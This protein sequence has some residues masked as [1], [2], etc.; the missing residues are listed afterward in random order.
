MPTEAITAPKN[1]LLG[2]GHL[3]LLGYTGQDIP[4]EATICV[5]E[6]RL[7]F[8][9]GGATL[10]YKPTSYTANDD[11]GYV[12]KSILQKED[13]IFK[14]GILTFNGETVKKLADTARVIEGQDGSRTTFIGG[15]SNA[16]NARY[17][18][19]FWH[20]DP[21]DGDV[22]V[23]IVGRNQAGFSLSFL[24][25]KET[26]IDAEFACEPMDADGTLVRYKE[27]GAAPDTGGNADTGGNEG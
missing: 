26:I 24:K 14:T 4:D 21:V 3:F 7:G 10:E 5:E 17:I 9:S 22:F 20:K 18:L 23:T 19:C 12:S 11:L 2:S 13:V 27:T 1:I 6:N 8:V 25:D 16:Q 15:I